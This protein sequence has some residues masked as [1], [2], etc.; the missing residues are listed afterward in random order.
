M[1]MAVSCVTYSVGVIGEYYNTFLME[2]HMF[3][4]QLQG[5]SPI[6]AVLT[7]PSL[8]CEPVKH[9]NKTNYRYNPNIPVFKLYKTR[10]HIFQ[11][12]YYKRNL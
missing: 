1:V 9:K 4:S 5:I 12:H 7:L 10:T 2:K 11:C 3:C 6:H 8:H